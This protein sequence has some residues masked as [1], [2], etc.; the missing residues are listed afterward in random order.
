VVRGEPASP[1]SSTH[2]KPRRPDQQGSRLLRRGSSCHFP[3]D[4]SVAHAG[5]SS[6]RSNP[7]SGL[8]GSRSLSPSPPWQARSH[9]SAASGVRGSREVSV[10]QARCSTDGACADA[11]GPVITVKRP[12]TAMRAANREVR[13]VLF[14]MVSFRDAVGSRCRA[15]WFQDSRAGVSTGYQSH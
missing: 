9:A 3:H 8:V 1:S 14:M 10:H 12:T 4:C 13:I 2:S 15:P 5:Q 7:A 11:D 6:R